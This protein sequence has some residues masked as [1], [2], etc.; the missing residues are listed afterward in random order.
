MQKTIPAESRE[1][2]LLLIR[3]AI[4]NEVAGQRFYSDAALHCIDP[5]AKEIFS[6]LAQDEDDHTRLLLAQHESLAT[7]GRW[8]DHQG[9]MNI[10]AQ[11]DITNL[12]FLDEPGGGELFPSSRPASQAVDRQGDDLDALAFG[13]EM[14]RA[15]INLYSRAASETDDPV[16]TQAYDFLVQEETRHLD[17]L[18]ERWERLSG[19]PFADP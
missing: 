15:A 3:Q 2:T 13:I 14:E 19:I 6:A 1:D 8:L 9:A 12:T 4:Q 16:A 10:Q 18:R 17:L 11:T 7:E 5:W